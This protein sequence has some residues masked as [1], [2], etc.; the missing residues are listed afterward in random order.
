MAALA[1]IDFSSDLPDVD[2]MEQKE[3]SALL[4]GFG[5]TPSNFLK[6]DAAVLKV[7]VRLG[8]VRGLG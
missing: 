1:A 6:D 2:S 8:S 3:V 4:R 7:R 5:R